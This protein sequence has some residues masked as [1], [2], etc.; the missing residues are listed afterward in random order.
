MITVL[1]DGN[2]I[3]AYA[4]LEKSYVTMRLYLPD[5]ASDE[6]IDAALDRVNYSV[7][8]KYRHLSEKPPIEKRWAA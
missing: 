8:N 1:A 2:E 7:I 6:D 3:Y 5:G 4:F